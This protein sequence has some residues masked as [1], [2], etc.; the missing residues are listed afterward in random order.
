MAEEKN[1]FINHLENFLL[2]HNI[3]TNI[4]SKEKLKDGQSSFQ[5]LIIHY[6]YETDDTAIYEDFDNFQDEQN[7][8]IHKYIIEGNSLFLS[9]NNE[10]LVT[11]SSKNKGSYQLTYF[12]QTGAISDSQQ[13]SLESTLSYLKENN[14]LPLNEEMAEFV[15]TEGVKKMNQPFNNIQK[16]QHLLRKI[17]LER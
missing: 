2:K 10:V 3:N 11:P 16:K 8:I 15:T 12:D 14:I 5:D 9:G 17:A 4:N 13:E 7:A 6:F 1:S